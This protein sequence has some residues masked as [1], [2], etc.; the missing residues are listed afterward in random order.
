MVF[1]VSCGDGFESGLEIGEGFDPV[2]FG[3]FDQRCDAAPGFAALVI[4]PFL[5]GL[6]R[7]IHAA[8]FSFMAGVIPPMAMLGRSLL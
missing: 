6:S 4:P 3:G 7:R 1:G 8:V 5:M 2:D